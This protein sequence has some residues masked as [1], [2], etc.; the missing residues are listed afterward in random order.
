VPSCATITFRP[1]RRWTA[2]GTRT[3]M[4]VAVAAEVL[5]PASR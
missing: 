5:R 1:P 4:L 2:I 3:V